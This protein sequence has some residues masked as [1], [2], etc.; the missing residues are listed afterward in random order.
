[1]VI[2]LARRLKGHVIIELQLVGDFG[3]ARLQ[4][5]RHVVVP[6]IDA[7]LLQP[8]IRGPAEIGGIDVCGQAFFKAVQLVGSNEVHLAGEAGLVAF[9]TEIMRPSGDGRG[10]LGGVVVD[11][12]VRDGSRPF[13]TVARAG[14]QSGL[15][16]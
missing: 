3:N 4:H 8:P 16:E 10:E 12:P 2:N 5:A 14:E 11:T 13:I 15:V 7:L 6:P 1:M 9:H